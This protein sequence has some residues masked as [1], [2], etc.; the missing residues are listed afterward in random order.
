[1]ITIQIEPA[2]AFDR[3]SILTV[4][5]FNLQDNNGDIQLLEKVKN[6]L[7]TLSNQISS[8][9]S[10]PRTQEIVD[11]EEYNDLLK[12]N[13]KLF[14][15]FNECKKGGMDA[16]IPDEYNWKRHLAKKTLQKKFFNEDFNEVKLGY[17][18]K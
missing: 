13:E 2:E 15:L 9:I 8:S 11:S 6:E 4:K 18:A 10:M 5:Y 14:N 16:L 3:F 7:Q 17:N 12:I 1:M